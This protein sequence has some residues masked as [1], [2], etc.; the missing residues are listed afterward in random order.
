MPTYTEITIPFNRSYKHLF[1]TL[2]CVDECL[3]TLKLPS[4]FSIHSSLPPS[5]PPSLSLSLPCDSCVQ[6]VGKPRVWANQECGQTKQISCSECS[7]SACLVSGLES[8]YS[9]VSICL[10]HNL[11]FQLNY[12]PVTTIV[13]Y[14]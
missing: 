13:H 9:E 3:H 4:S 7:W 1:L 11:S 6:S 14:R 12:M 5:L 2:V 8:V 10:D